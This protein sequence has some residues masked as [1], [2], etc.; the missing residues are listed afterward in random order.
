MIENVLTTIIKLMG[1]A[2]KCKLDDKKSFVLNILK[3]TM[4]IDDYERYEPIISVCID[5]IKN[6]AK[7]KD[8]LKDLKTN[9]ICFKSC[10]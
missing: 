6:I 2:Q 1:E 9:S 7:N 8:L 4:S 3:N 5:L 10:I